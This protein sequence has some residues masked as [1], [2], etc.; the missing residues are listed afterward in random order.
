MGL[1]YRCRDLTVWRPC[2]T[3]AHEEA[4]D[5]PVLT[6]LFFAGFIILYVLDR[7]GG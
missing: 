5:T 4:P 6:G 2:S 7:L 3:E 1:R